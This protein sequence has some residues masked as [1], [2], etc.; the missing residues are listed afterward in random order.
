ML[1]CNDSL[2]DTDT[3]GSRPVPSEQNGTVKFCLK[4]SD[5]LKTK[6]DFDGV[7]NN[8]KRL[9]CRYFTLLIL[10]DRSPEN[11]DQDIQCG[12]IC[13]RKFHKRAVV[14]NRARRVVWESFRLLKPRMLPCR[15][16]VIP[17]RSI[18]TA[19]MNDVKTQ[20]ESLLNR[21]QRLNPFQI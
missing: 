6:W 18:C 12:V 5:K 8:G 20:L 13:S 21:E 4:E 19:N 17:K 16:V 9:T 11:P 7:K 3:T 15:I 1:E 14:R 2:K 10:I